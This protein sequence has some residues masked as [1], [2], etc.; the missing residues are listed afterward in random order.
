MF[1][2]MFTKKLT[3]GVSENLVKSWS[4]TANVLAEITKTCFPPSTPATV[5]PGSPTFTVCYHPCTSM[6]SIA[7]GKL[8]LVSEE[9]RCVVCIYVGFVK[10][11]CL[12]H[13]LDT[14]L[15]SLSL[16]K[17]AIVLLGQNCKQSHWIEGMGVP[18]GHCL[19]AHSCRSLALIAVAKWV[20]PSPPT[21]GWCQRSSTAVLIWPSM[22]FRQKSRNVVYISGR[23]SLLT[24]RSQIG[25]GSPF[26][27]SWAIRASTSHSVVLELADLSP[28]S[29]P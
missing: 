26:S 8:P 28:V 29:H 15:T 27:K 14:Q 17:A 5:Q 23:P 7:D 20:T 21:T 18:S 9:Y 24:R 12:Y 19:A 1:W 6:Q 13:E 3:L 10:L 16:S 22:C 4:A 2:G 25:S 11:P